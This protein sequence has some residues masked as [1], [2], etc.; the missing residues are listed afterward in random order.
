MQRLTIDGVRHDIGLGGWSLT[1]LA[2]ARD[3]AFKNRR[4]ARK[5]GD[6]RQSPSEAPTFREAAEIKH[7]ELKPSWRNAKHAESWLQS[8]EKH[9]YPVLADMRVDRIKPTHVLGVL[10][11][12]GIH[13]GRLPRGCVSAFARS[14]LGAKDMSM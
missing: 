13:V 1:S 9:A 8:L 12:S 2:E 10:K 6:P 14:W 4:I 11:P 5:G 7:A 3:E